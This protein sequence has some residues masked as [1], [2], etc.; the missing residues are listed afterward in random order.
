MSPIAIGVLNSTA[1]INPFLH[2]ADP[3][4]PPE[5]TMT[6]GQGELVTIGPGDEAAID[7]FPRSISVRHFPLNVTPGEMFVKFLYQGFGYHDSPQVRLI[8]R[9]Q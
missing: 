6:F 9:G 4:I 2:V 7:T 1:C 3:Y 5:S 8:V